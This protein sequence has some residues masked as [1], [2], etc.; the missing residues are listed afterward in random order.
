VKLPVVPVATKGLLCFVSGLLKQFLNP[1]LAPGEFYVLIR[2]KLPSQ[3]FHLLI[4][5][6]ERSAKIFSLSLI[7][8][9]ILAGS[10]ATTNAQDIP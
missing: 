5:Q 9:A 6:P 4:Y 1:R 3:G 8:G 2:D 10:V 7:A